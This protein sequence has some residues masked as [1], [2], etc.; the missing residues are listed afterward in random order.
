M[1]ITQILLFEDFLQ[2][3]ET[4]I[5]QKDLHEKL[6]QCSVVASHSVNDFENKVRSFNYDIVILDIMA[7]PP[8]N[9]YWHDVKEDGVEVPETFVGIELLRRCCSGYYGDH[10]KEIPIYM[11]TARGEDEIRNLCDAIGSTGYFAPGSDDPALI[12]EIKKHVL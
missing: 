4:Y 12:E 10:Y 11:R 9:F 7:K 3:H 8:A 5:F 1:G 2:A 6:N